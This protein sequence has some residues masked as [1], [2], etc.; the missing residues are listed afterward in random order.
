MDYVILVSEALGP[1]RPGIYDSAGTRLGEGPDEVSYWT[2]TP[3][4]DGSRLMIQRADSPTEEARFAVIE[5]DGSTTEIDALVIGHGCWDWHTNDELLVA[6]IGEEATELEV[7]RLDDG[8]VAPITTLPGKWCVAHRDE[9]S[10]VVVGADLEGRNDV[11]V[12]DLQSGELNR[13]VT[14]DCNLGHV[15]V[16]PDGGTIATSAACADAAPESTTGA[17]Q[18]EILIIDVDSGGLRRI[19]DGVWTSP[20]FTPDGRS[21]IAADLAPSGTPE[22]SRVIRIDLDTDERTILIEGQS[23][24]LP[25]VVPG[26]WR[27]K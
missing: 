9:R 18:S 15:R 7:L 13:V 2:P 1:A 24:I 19:Q 20:S 11:A 22:A 5:H 10:A 8:A 12:I 25:V 23:T 21:I 16:S 26:S 14:V 4:P 17:T 3:S 27:P 6:H